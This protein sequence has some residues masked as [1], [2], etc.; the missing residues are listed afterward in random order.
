MV[1][2]FGQFMRYHKRKILSKNSMEYM[3]WKLV[4]DS[5]LF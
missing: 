3:A 4:P 5:F 2:N 1:M